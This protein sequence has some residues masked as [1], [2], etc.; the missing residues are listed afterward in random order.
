MAG[1]QYERIMD[2]TT[3]GRARL[4]DERG[5]EIRALLTFAF[6][7]D[8]DSYQLK[9]FGFRGDDPFTEAVE[10]SIQRFA[11]VELHPDK[12][13]PTFRLFTQPRFW[14]AQK[15]GRSGYLRLKHAQNGPKPSDPAE[16][17]R[18]GHP[19]PDNAPTHAAV[20][21]ASPERMGEA[22][23]RL[24][25]TL[26]QL[27]ARTCADLVDYWLIATFKWRARWLGWTDT[28]VV[29]NA[30]PKKKTRSFYKHDA[31]FRFQCLHWALIEE[32]NTSAPALVVRE[33]MFRPCVNEPPYRQ[34]DDIVA[35]LL[36]L[37]TVTGPR[38]IGKLRRAGLAKLLLR[39]AGRAE[40]P[41][42]ETGKIEHTVLRLS[43]SPTTVHALDLERHQGLSE[44]LRA[45][46][47][48]L[49][50]EP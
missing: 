10:W 18:A 32:G 34:A 7:R 16:L 36:P 48:S 20:T 9:S 29:E 22:G 17:E 19:T 46:K 15:V 44:R 14:L 24:S 5:D 47:P 12:C 13:T 4:V 41:A 28:A 21:T 43:L 50:E 2:W 23:K 27:A 38:T 42:D 26:R 33:S 49:E 8:Y 31:Q 1:T 37:S 40:T 30:P 35:S 6:R 45:L 3:A 25:E 11:T 39:L